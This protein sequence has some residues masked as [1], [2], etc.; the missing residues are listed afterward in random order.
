VELFRRWG[1]EADAKETETFVATAKH[2]AV[3]TTARR[4]RA[5]LGA[6]DGGAAMA[7]LADLTVLDETNAEAMREQVRDSLSATMV[8]DGV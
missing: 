7:L 6:V 1:L 5:A 3:E 8:G 4:L 2:K